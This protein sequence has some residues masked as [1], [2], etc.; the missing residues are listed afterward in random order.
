MTETTRT[1]LAAFAGANRSSKVRLPLDQELLPLASVGILA[2]ELVRNCRVRL[3][4][5]GEAQLVLS[6]DL[7]TQNRGSKRD[8]IG[9]V[10]NFILSHAFRQRIGEVSA[11]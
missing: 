11:E 10:L 8:A 6:I 4:A 2:S 7:E 1:I 5:E 3:D 9:E